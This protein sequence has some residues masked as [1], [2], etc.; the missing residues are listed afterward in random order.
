M[1]FWFFEVIKM[2]A[3]QAL[4][5]ID[6]LR[7]GWYH[8]PTRY[9]IKK[10]EFEYESYKCSGIDEI[11]LYLMRH[12]GEDPIMTV[13]RFRHMMD[14]FACEAKTSSAN[15]MFSVYYDVAT[16]VLDVLLNI[17]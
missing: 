7:K 17:K 12:K 10:G 16:D 2:T 8:P 4:S 13:E 6:S 5:A 15:F 14:D 11:K 1:A 9:Y 3:N